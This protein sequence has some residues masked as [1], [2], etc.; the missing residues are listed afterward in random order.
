LCAAPSATGSG[1]CFLAL[2]A[3]VCLLGWS[4]VCARPALAMVP[5]ATAAAAR[6]SRGAG[7]VDRRARIFVAVAASVCAVLPVCAVCVCVCVSVC[8]TLIIRP[9]AAHTHT[10]HTRAQRMA[11]QQLQDSTTRNFSGIVAK[12]ATRGTA[13]MHSVGV[14]FV[15]VVPVVPV[16]VARRCSCA[17]ACAWRTGEC[18]SLPCTACVC[19]C[20]SVSVVLSVCLSVCLCAC[21]FARVRACVARH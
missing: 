21:V 8:L 3:C 14:R 1:R 16:A 20:V 5:Y 11:Q 9:P 17:R 2:V 13:T 18:R 6:D 15:A 4:A 7:G 12:P 10:H 19:V